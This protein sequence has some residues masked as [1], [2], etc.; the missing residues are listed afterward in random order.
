MPLEHKTGMCW[1]CSS[2]SSPSNTTTGRSSE[3]DASCLFVIA[4]RDDDLLRF[5]IHAWC[6]KGV[7]ERR[8]EEFDGTILIRRYLM[9]C[10]I[11][12]DCD[13]NFSQCI[14]N[15]WRSYHDQ[16]VSQAYNH[17]PTRLNMCM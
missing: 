2:S 9:I 1:V 17:M 3:K 16:T 12:C 10:L 8:M 7:K 6:A 14:V 11:P 5:S 13:N 4:E 15:I